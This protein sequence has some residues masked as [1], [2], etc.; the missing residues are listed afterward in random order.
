MKNLLKKIFILMLLILPIASTFL[1]ASPVNAYY[2]FK[3]GDKECFVKPNGQTECTDTGTGGSSSGSSTSP[4]TSSFRSGSSCPSF[5]GLT[6]WDCGVISN[7][8][9]EGDL[10]NG[11]L[12]IAANVAVDITVIAAYLVLGY[13]IY[14]GYLYMFS[15]GDAGKVANGKK[16]IVHAF[17]GLAIVMSAYIIMGAIRTVLV[18][19]QFKDC[20]ASEGACA[21]P[22]TL[23]SSMIS[24]VIGMAGV[25]SA[26]FLVYGGISYITS[27][28]D[29]N[30]L[31]KAKN[32]IMYALIGM[33]IVALSSVITAFVSNT[34]KDAQSSSSNIIN[35]TIA[36]EIYE[37]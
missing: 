18:G 17:I 5:L 27:A 33:A 4:T 2:T 37:K 19:G 3:D 34:I 21:N 36:K 23:V 16:T 12:Q 10:K 6:S 8:G 26:I 13:V 25:I 7:P 15:S 30:K 35:K 22:T 20:L 29:A 1:F 9:S 11:I 31:Q 32:T 28:G 14:G 24:W